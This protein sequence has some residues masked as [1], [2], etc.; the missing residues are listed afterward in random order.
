M[1]LW[2]GAIGGKGYGNFSVPGD[3]GA[4]MKTVYAHR[5]AFE[6][7]HGPIPDGMSA[8]HTCDTPLCVNPSHLWAGTAKDNAEDASVKGRLGA[9]ADQ[10]KCDM[11]HDMKPDDWIGKTSK[12]KSGKKDV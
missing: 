10:S 2:K 4:H 12:R 11:G 7:W 3:S 1:W 8:C 6:L 9:K 5:Y